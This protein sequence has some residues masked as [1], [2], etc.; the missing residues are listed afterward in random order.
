VLEFIRQWMRDRKVLMPLL[1]PV[2]IW[3]EE[4]IFV[5]LAGLLGNMIVSF[6]GRDKRYDE[7][8]IMYVES[9]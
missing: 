3:K 7:S 6:V 9:N 8:Q 2:K 1:F 4:G 5:N